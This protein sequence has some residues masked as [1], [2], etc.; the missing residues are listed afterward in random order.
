MIASD[1]DV[2][3]TAPKL[4][5]LVERATD[6]QEII[7]LKSGNQ[8]KAVLISAETFEY[9]V[10]LNKYR[11]SET[12]PADEFEK[13]FHQA[14]VDAGYDSREKILD[15]VREVKQELYEERQQQQ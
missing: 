11:R 7:T 3:T 10:G 9:L 2:N 13:G 8:K 12:M 4:S 6:S 15:L 5:D 14:L 1:I